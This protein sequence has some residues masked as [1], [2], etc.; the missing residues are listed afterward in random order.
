MYGGSRPSRPATR[1]EKVFRADRRPA[2][3]V[4]RNW[5]CHP[6]FLTFLGAPQWNSG[7]LSS[8]L[9]CLSEEPFPLGNP[10]PPE[11]QEQFRVVAKPPRRS[12][13]SC[14]RCIVPCRLRF[15]P[16][17]PFL[18]VPPRKTT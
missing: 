12:K 3:L 18:S 17:E 9:P 5:D 14:R 8:S 7:I 1:V 6:S 11:A 10:P 4:V 15:Q 2:T 16:P 13:Q